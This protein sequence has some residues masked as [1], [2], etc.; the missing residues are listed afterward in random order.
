[1]KTL[2]LVAA[3]LTALLAWQVHKAVRDSM[4]VREIYGDLIGYPGES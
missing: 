2:I 4:R 3:A 1:M